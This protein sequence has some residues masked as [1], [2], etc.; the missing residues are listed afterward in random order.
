MEQLQESRLCVNLVTAGEGKKKVNWK[1]EN[2]TYRQIREILKRLTQLIRSGVS[3]AGNMLSMEWYPK[4][5][6]PQICVVFLPNVGAI[7][8]A[9]NGLSPFDA[10]TLCDEVIWSIDHYILKGSDVPAFNHRLPS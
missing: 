8:A 4:D 1:F 3:D 5:P 2:L 6:D 9:I 10:C 7:R